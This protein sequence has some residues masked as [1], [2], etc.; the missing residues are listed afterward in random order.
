[1]T[2]EELLQ[3]LYEGT[4]SPAENAEFEMRSAESP[5][6]A[7]EV[8]QFRA[9][10]NLLKTETEE[11]TISPFVAISAREKTIAVIAAAAG[12]ATI[13]GAAASSSSGG[14]FTSVAV[15]WLIGA[16]TV[17]T[18][19]GIAVWNF[20][21]RFEPATPAPSAELKVAPAP[22]QEEIKPAQPTI[23]EP[24][25]KDN[26]EKQIPAKPKRVESQA[27][28]NQAT[29]IITENQAEIRRQ[30]EANLEHFSKR[31]EQQKTLGNAGGEAT[32]TMSIGMTLRE[33]KQF[34][35]AKKSFEEAFV[36]AEKIGD[37]ETQGLTL[38]EIGLVYS[39]QGQKTTARGKLEAGLKFLRDSG[40]RFIG[41]YEE[42][43][44]KISK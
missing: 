21:P 30:L 8:R 24:K 12:A 23:P 38:C 11:D 7:E 3:K 28:E 4:L 20:M 22:K 5:E 19:G 14:F 33:L 31:K 26:I 27:D 18:L 43:L 2:N 29:G 32:A 35:E 1:M 10:E 15:Q 16:L 39:A 42:E 37:T 9:V 41:K 25:I 36:L 40:S 6:F 44:K 17:L 34:T 13:G